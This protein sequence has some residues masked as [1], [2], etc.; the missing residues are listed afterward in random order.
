MRFQVTHSIA[1]SMIVFFVL[2]SFQEMYINFM[3]NSRVYTDLFFLET[4]LHK[5]IGRKLWIVAA[6]SP[7]GIKAMGVW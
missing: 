1:F 3:G 7:L 6:C 5:L 4:K 2:I